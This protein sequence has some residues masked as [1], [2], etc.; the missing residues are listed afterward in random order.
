M[1]GYNQGERGSLMG[2]QYILGRSGSGKTYHCYQSI[3][4][5]LK[6][7]EDHA[8]ILIVPEQFTLQ[9]QK[10]FVSMQESKG[11]IRAEVLSF[12][13]LAYRIFDELGG[14]SQRLLDEIGKGLIVQRVGEQYKEQLEV[15]KKSLQKPGFIKTVGTTISEFYQYNIEPEQ[16][17]GYIGDLDSTVLLQKKMQDIYILYEGFQKYIEKE[18]MALEQMLDQVSKKI[19][20]S[21]WLENA[22]IWID[23][24][25]GFTPQQYKV[26][27]QLARKAKQVYITLTIDFQ[28]EARKLDSHI[29]LIETD[30]FFES[31]K[32]IQKLNRMAAFY[33]IPIHSPV[34][35]PQDPPYRFLGNEEFA[36]L[37]KQFLAYLPQKYIK[38]TKNIQLYAGSNPYIEVE[39]TAKKILEL[40]REKGYRF[41]DIAVVTAGLGQYQ[42]LVEALYTQYQI[43][44]F[45]DQKQGI[46]HQPL[47]ELVRSV[48]Q[49]FIQY[50]SYESVFRYLKTGLLPIDS[51]HIF[52]LENYVLAHGI[53]GITQWR[54]KDWSEVRSEDELEK[55]Q[56]E[57]IQ[58]T[59]DQVLEPLL[60]FRE[61]I[62][63]SGQVTV[64]DITVALYELLEETEVISMIK[65]QI[66]EFQQKRKHLLVSEMLQSWNI[67]MDVLEKIVE[68]VGLQKVSIKEYAAILDAGLEQCEMGLVP[69]GLDQVVVGDFR[70]SRLQNIRALFILGVNDGI[71]P[72]M[73]EQQGVFSDRE[74]LAMTSVGMEIAPDGRRRAFEEQF[75]IYLGL[76][77][78]SEYLHISYA[79]GDAEG[80]ALR[81]SMLITKIKSIFPKVIESNDRQNTDPFTFIG[82]PKTTFYHLGRAMR[83][84]MESQKIDPLWLD[85][86][87]WFYEKPEWK[88]FL[89]RMV[90]GLFHTNQEAML[91]NRSTNKLYGDKLY[92]SVSRLEKFIACPFAYFIEY[93][94]GAQ[95][96]QFYQ[97]EAP[98]MGRLFHQVLDGFSKKLIRR[99][100]DWRTIEKEQAHQLIDETMEEV[101]QNI[102]YGV[103]LSSYRNK[104]LVHRLKRITKRAIWALQE[105][106]CRGLFEPLGFEIGF[107]ENEALPPIVIDLSQGQKLILTG[108]ID[109]VDILDEDGTVYIKIIDY[110]SGS[111]DFQLVD[112]YYGIQLQLILYLDALLNSGSSIFHK[113]LLPAGMFYFHID[114]PMISAVQD[115]TDE[116]IQTLILKNLKLSG[117]VLA[118]IDIIQKMDQSMERYSDILPVQLTK[119]GISKR[120]SVATMEEFQQLRTYMRELV[121]STGE[122]ILQGNIQIYPYKVKNQTPCEYCLYDGI[123]QFDTLLEDNQYHI[124]PQI[125]KEKIWKNIKKAEE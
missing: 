91:S 51:E 6:K 107:G 106:I 120:S 63:P 102:N 4:K 20:D 114:D 101:A 78:P 118:D 2:L 7:P 21:T 119:S 112:I 12:Q 123:C 43:P 57:Q 14:P 103:F 50:W 79:L 22:E 8:L 74:R 89:V 15:F 111:Q 5:S 64:K 125:E 48:L 77:K 19:P 44:H 62:L 13:R 80:K 94:L 28:G 61:K 86:Y 96:R 105:H 25:Y 54:N 39:Q 81:P 16:L 109:R 11:M 29:Q 104:Y 24:F 73:I 35:L 3:Q 108:R 42:K 66:N 9:T 68:V 27:Y 117:L 33:D 84:G 30:P 92:T 124:L 10:D 110:K 83:R 121:Q 97:L 38:P 95:E 56:Q 75:L 122:E 45:I 113:E 47:I 1:S 82:R 26:L 55:L 40:V 99:D 93:G 59:K 41:R 85:T 98:D 53:R 23:G 18:Y 46:M 69:P 115:L 88:D 60:A 116:E 31:K 36:H 87:S 71:L 65:G 72:S 76:T 52:L 90:K 34:V 49:I 37:E 32:T 17:L 67:L 100:L 58:V 70:R